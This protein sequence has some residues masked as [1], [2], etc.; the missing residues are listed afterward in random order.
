MLRTYPWQRVFLM[1]SV[2][3]VEGALGIEVRQECATCN[4]NT[5]LITSKNPGLRTVHGNRY[6]QF[7]VHTTLIIKQFAQFFCCY[8]WCN[9]FDSY[10]CIHFIPLLY[11]IYNKEMKNTVFSRFEIRNSFPFLSC[12]IQRKSL[13]FKLFYSHN[14]INSFIRNSLLKK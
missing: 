4:Q 2:L 3:G 14:L 10:T 9:Y 12:T 5:S 13:Q 1:Q 11:H 8:N 7:Y 6:V